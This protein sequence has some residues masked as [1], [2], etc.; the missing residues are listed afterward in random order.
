MS[1]KND[2][3][4]QKFFSRYFADNLKP[5]FTLAEVLI[6]LGI[7]GVV[8]ALTIPNVTSHYRKK[9]VETRLA[10]FY[11]V[12][13]QAVQMSEKDNGPKEYWE[14][15][16]SGD[17][18]EVEGRLVPS[19]WFE[20][21]LKPYI[22]YTKVETNTSSG[23]L[24]IYFADGSLCLIGSGSFQFWP[25]AGNFVDYA[26]DEGAGEYKNNAE[27][28]GIKYFTFQFSPYTD[29]ANN[30]YHYKKGV[31]PYKQHWDGTVEMLKENSSIGCRKDVSNERAYCAAL[32]QQ[33][34]WK[35]PDDY[36][37]KF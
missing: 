33:N 35:I 26:F 6:T 4:R 22:K 1:R 8:A 15:Q 21:Y 7:I 12:M 19:V 3:R 37:L 32:I 2:L 20:K 11:T 24:M 14:Q 25:E 31:E 27:I 5:A 10:K 28:S 36:P 16:T 30:K 17:D 29:T 18:E 23:K 34:G 13:N 9:V